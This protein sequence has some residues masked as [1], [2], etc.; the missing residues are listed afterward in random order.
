M[1]YTTGSLM[2]TAFRVSSDTDMNVATQAAE[3]PLKAKAL[4]PKRVCFVC[5]GNTCRS[6]MA[7]AVT[8]ALGKNCGITAES[9]GIYANE[10]ERI[11]HNALEALLDAGYIP[12]EGN[13]FDEH[14]SATI[15]KSTFE[16]CDTV[17]AISRSHFMSL[18]YSFPSYV[19][20]IT[21][22]PCDI[23]DPFGGDLNRYKACL[24]EITAGVKELLGF[25][26]DKGRTL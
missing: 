23:S 20:K 3:T 13:R 12:E 22:M 1:T 26:S 19:Q 10:G 6:P 18:I 16:T 15:C 2:M 11:S 21:V 25:E 9:A 4:L 7:A 14:R 8:N 24:E 17:I 5:T